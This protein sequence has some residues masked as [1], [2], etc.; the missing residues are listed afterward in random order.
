[1]V[2]EKIRVRNPCC[3][4]YGV[5]LTLSSVDGNESLPMNYVLSFDI[6]LVSAYTFLLVANFE[7][8]PHLEKLHQSHLA[9]TKLNRI[10]C[11]GRIV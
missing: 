2:N 5:A 4:G 8:W 6:L 11:F 7:G 10:L 1:M 3:K 9:V